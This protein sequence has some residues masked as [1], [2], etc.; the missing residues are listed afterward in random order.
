VL[1]GVSEHTSSEAAEVVAFRLFIGR[2]YLISLRQPSADERRHYVETRDRGWGDK[3]FHF[4]SAPLR[5]LRL[6]L[7]KASEQVL[8]R[9]SEE[10]SQRVA[11]SD[12]RASA[13]GIS[14]R[15]SSRTS[16]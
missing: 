9:L 3:A 8:V 7:A 10:R 14:R 16:A 15:H 5:L 6:E 13:T 11:V 1:P 4:A 2:P 12:I